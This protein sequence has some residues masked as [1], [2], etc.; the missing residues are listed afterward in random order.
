MFFSD[1]SKRRVRY[2]RLLKYAS[3]FEIFIFTVGI[4][5]SACAGAS[6]PIS[7]LFFSSTVNEFVSPA[8]GDFNDAIEKM[9]ILGAI[10]F[11]IAFIQMLCLQY[12]A[13]RQAKKIRQ[14][15]FSVSVFTYLYFRIKIFLI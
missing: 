1:R 5:C 11:V 7:L 14:L 13:K 12:C 2:Y 6:V 9:A 15:I 10:R 4:F 3:A 8:V